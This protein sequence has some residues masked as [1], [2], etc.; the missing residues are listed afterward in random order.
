LNKSD[1]GVG[2]ESTSRVGFCGYFFVSSSLAIGFGIN[3]FKDF[4]VFDYKGIS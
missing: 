4:W 3:L 1:L 2:M